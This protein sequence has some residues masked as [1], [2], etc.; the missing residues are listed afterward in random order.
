MSEPVTRLG[1]QIPNFGDPDTVRSK[2]D[3]LERHCADVGRDPAEITKTVL[4]TVGDPAA[5]GES[6]AAYRAVGACPRRTL[7]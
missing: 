2:L 3:V 1:L 6:I 7:S 4:L 5:A